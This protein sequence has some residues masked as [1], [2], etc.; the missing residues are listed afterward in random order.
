MLYSG[1]DKH[2]DNCFIVTVN[3]QGTVLKE[4][5]VKNTVAALTAYFTSFGSE[6]HRAVVESTTGW[7]WLDDLLSSLGIEMLLAHAK[8]LRAIAY[9]KVKTDRMD[10]HTLAHLLRLG[11]V[12][13][14][15]KI[16]RE[17]RDTRDL[18]R[19]RLRLVY[20]RTACYNSIHRPGE[21]YNCDHL[22]DADKALFPEEL[23]ALVKEQIQCQVA[24][25]ALLNS[26]TARLEKLV[27]ERLVESDDVR[28]LLGAPAVG[29]VTA[30]TLYLEIDG[31]ERFETE[32]QFFSH[33][34]V[35]PGANNSN[36]TLRHKSGNKEG[37][38]YLK[39]AL[40]DAA[41]HAIRYY[42]EFRRFYQKQLRRH[43]KA[44]TLTLVAKEMA[45]IVYHIL[46]DKTEYTGLK[47]QPIERQ[48]QPV[49]LRR[50]RRR[51][52]LSPGAQG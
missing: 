42:P 28:R 44:I 33:T 50:V 25:I 49:R 21:K 10:A 17:L 24:Q 1:I 37:N 16:S 5:R 15:H 32:K 34:R 9:V 20:K 13:E 12:P 7:Y 11:Y 48:K 3:E 38:K 46:K 30:F 47:G 43:K 18:T 52:T 39:I 45:R 2:K 51:L 22:I 41:V 29:L 19:A 8:Y 35:V 31:I 26:Q 4:A 27:R 36:K 23:P 40:T 6:P 14:A